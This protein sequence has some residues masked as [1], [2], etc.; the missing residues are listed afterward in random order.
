MAADPASLTVVFTCIGRRVELVQAFRAAGRR[1]A[2]PLRIVG[3]DSDP[4]A[5]AL[6][7]VDKAVLVP[8][9]SEPAYIARVLAT[10][11]AEQANLL[12]PTTDTDLPVLSAHRDDFAAHA[13]HA[14]IAESAVIRTC[15]DK[16]LTYA[17]LRRHGIDTPTTYTPDELARLATKPFPLFIKPRTGSASQWVHRID[18]QLELD[19]HLRQ[20]RD[21]IIQAFVVGDEYTLDVYVGLGGV[22]QCVV[23]RRR[24]QVRTGEVSKGLVVKDLEIMNAGRRVVETLGTSPRGVVTLQCAASGSSRSTRASAAAS[25][26]RS[27]PGRISRSGSCGSSA[28][29]P[30]APPSTSSNT[31]SACSAMIGRSSCPSA[32]TCSPGCT[33]PC[34]PRR[35]SAENAGAQRFPLHSLVG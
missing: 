6:S 15:R 25:R 30:Q 32:R 27:R 22:P 28:A 16:I 34:A 3:L 21:P 29:S 35:I 10:T 13:C 9:V 19:Y 1:L 18:D 5:P 2:V 20:V 4:T 7:C 23:P 24:L 26:C 8:R 17:H 12:V 33:R 11:A 31:G 14:L